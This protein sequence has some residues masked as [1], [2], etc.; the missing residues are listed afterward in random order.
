VQLRCHVRRLPTEA[1]NRKIVSIED[2]DI[3]ISE[4]FHDDLCE[5]ID[6]ISVV[7]FND[8]IGF[9]HFTE[10]KENYASRLTRIRKIF[11]QKN[12]LRFLKLKTG[13]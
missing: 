4:L 12:L 8:P 11:S 2:D 13:C 10:N 5:N 9:E 7:A 1:T 6:G 3:H